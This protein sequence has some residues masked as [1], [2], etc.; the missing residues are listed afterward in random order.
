MACKPWL[1][2]GTNIASAPFRF[3]IAREG[4][5]AIVI[6]GLQGCPKR[7]YDQYSYRKLNDKLTKFL[8]ENILLNMFLKLS[9]SLQKNDPV[10]R[11]CA[12]HHLSSIIERCS[13][14]PSNFSICSQIL[15][16]NAITLAMWI[17]T[18][19]CS[20]QSLISYSVSLFSSFLDLSLSIEARWKTAVFRARADF[21]CFHYQYFVAMW[22]KDLL[23]SDVLCII[24][25]LPTKN[26][27]RW[28]ARRQNG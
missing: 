28:C 7:L 15:L 8:A 27:W 16:I 19:S 6:C 4:E 10:Y 12:R 24:N 25:S 9:F 26:Q 1:L 5:G 23:V 17:Y 20:V 22:T 3:Q 11:F 14:T 18:V 13:L 2:T 21:A